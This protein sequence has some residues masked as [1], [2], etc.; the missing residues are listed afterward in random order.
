MSEHDVDLGLE[1]LFSRLVWVSGLVRERA[2]DAVAELLVDQN[3]AVV[4]TERLFRWF[5]EQQFESITALGV[6]ALLKAKAKSTKWLPPPRELVSEH[7]GKP[8]ILTTLLLGE[9][10]EDTS[11]ELDPTGWYTE[12][13]PREYV[14]DPF[15]AKYARTFLPPLYTHHAD[16]ITR[17]MRIP[18]SP[19]WAFEWDHLVESVGVPKSEGPLHFHGT[20]HRDHYSVFDTAMSEVYRSAFLRALAWAVAESALPAE[21]ALRFALQSCDLDAVLWSIEPVARPSWWPVVG[22]PDGSIDTIPAQIWH[23][24]STAWEDQKRDA[25][26]Q[27]V[28]C[29]DGRVYA[30][31]KVV[32][33]LQVMGVFQRAVGKSAPKHEQTADWLSTMPCAGWKGRGLSFGGWIDALD[34]TGF[35]ATLDDWVLMPAVL[36]VEPVCFHRMEWWKVYRSIWVPFPCTP[37][38]FHCMSDGLRVSESGEESAKWSIWAYRLREKTAGMLTPSSGYQLLVSRQV[39]QR[40]CDDYKCGFCWLCRL[41]CH[42]RDYDGNEWKVHTDFRSYGESGIVRL[43]G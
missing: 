11:C 41:T 3:H 33:D 1:I 25:L 17:V 7:L 23:G 34:I 36:R 35:S 26:P 19:Q 13:A 21:V 30:D 14:P 27:V 37:A 24:V 28:A 12:A 8:S 15:F 9:L 22:K 40:I 29:A 5:S 32:Y 16:R 39:I 18:F 43:G 6:L 2:C 20:E 4:V 38:E 31:G 10:Y 42:H